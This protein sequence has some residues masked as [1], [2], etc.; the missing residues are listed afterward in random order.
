MGPSTAIK[1]GLYEAIAGMGV[2]TYAVRPQAVDGGDN[3]DYP[4]I[5]IGFVAISA[6]DHS[7]GNGHDFTARIYT[8]WRGS[9]EAP[10]MAIQDAMYDRIHHG[11][12]NITGFKVLSFERQ[13]TNITHLQG[14]FEGLCE[15]HGLIVAA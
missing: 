11:V 3:A 13:T 10:G 7:T 4:H 12:I 2:K 9:S 15:Y 8:R 14:S 5:Q 6:Y 1:Q